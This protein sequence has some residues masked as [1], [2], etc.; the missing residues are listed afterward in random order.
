MQLGERMDEYTLLHVYF[1][2]WRTFSIS[3]YRAP[4]CRSNIYSQW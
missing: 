4:L 3:Q 2:I 1:I